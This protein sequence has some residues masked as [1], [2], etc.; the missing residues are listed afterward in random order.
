MTYVLAAY[1]VAAG[2]LILYEMRLW[3]EF[4][5]QREKRRESRPAE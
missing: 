2:A 1:T 3:G 5:R 4:C